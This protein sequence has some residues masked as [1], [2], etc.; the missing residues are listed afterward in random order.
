LTVL[1]INVKSFDDCLYLLDGRINCLSTLIIYVQEIAYTLGTIDNTVSI[2][3]N[4]CISRKK[5][6]ELDR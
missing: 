3:L 2:I 6:S 4:Y 1:K 5:I